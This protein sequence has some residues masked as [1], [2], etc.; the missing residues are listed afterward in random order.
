MRPYGL[1]LAG[2]GAKGAYQIGAWKA[3]LELGIEFEAI[4][5]TS[6]GAI[7]GALI[8]QGD[9]D[10][11]YRF[12]SNA[13]LENGVNLPEDLKSNEKL[14]SFSNFP[15]LF[16]EIIKNG[17]VDITPAKQLVEKC[18][19]EALVRQSKISLG[20]VTVQLSGMK[21]IEMFIEEMP[22]GSLIDYLM[23]SARFPGL[24]N[25]GPED[26]QYL[27]GGVYDNAPI[28]MLRKKGINRLVV[29]DISSRKGVGHREDWSCAD[30]IYI[31]PYDVKELGEVMEFDREANERRMNMGYFDARKAFGMLYGLNYYFSKRE[32]SGMLADYGYKT[33]EQLEG[34]ASQ[35]GVER[36]RVY[37]RRQFLKAVKDAYELYLAEKAAEEAAKDTAK[38]EK[39]EEKEKEKEKK[40]EEKEKEKKKKKDKEKE[41]E[42][43][44]EI[45][46]ENEDG[47]EPEAEEKK[48]KQSS[49]SQLKQ[50]VLSRFSK[51][52]KLPEDFPLAIELL[53]TL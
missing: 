8:A 4:A 1:I 33:C 51:K 14:F 52:D 12:W 15:Q 7:N 34:L 23:A 29:V 22:D 26:I 50:M 18:V 27:D 10:T 9:F 45:E 49:I 37:T 21:P 42:I 5:G 38:E 24:S 41:P 43:E 16:H 44:I 25:Q 32:Y 3:M 53:E 20:I 47:A 2:G 40:K 30:I 19:N 36:I 17:G 46:T 28:G 39:K 31:R 48:E 11:A 13:N 35:L 6:I